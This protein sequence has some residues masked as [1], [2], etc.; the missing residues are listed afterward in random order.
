MNP[1]LGCL[2]RRREYHNTLTADADKLES[3][4]ESRLVSKHWPTYIRVGL[5]QD[6]I[7]FYFELQVDQDSDDADERRL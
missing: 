4:Q 5:D 6:L 3:A 1:L 2:C 7:T